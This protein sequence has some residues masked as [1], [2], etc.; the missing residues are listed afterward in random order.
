VAE[1]PWIKF[2]T[3]D[4]LTGVADLQ[5]EEIGIYTVLLALI[6]DKGGPIADDAAWLARRAGTST[7]KFN[8]VR[9]RLIELGKLEA[10]NGL[11]ANRRALDEVT[12]RDGKSA[13]ARNA[14]LTRWKVEGEP[15]LPLGQAAKPVGTKV[16]PRA[17]ARSADYLPKNGQING[18]NSEDKDVLISGNNQQEPQKSAIPGDADACFPSRAGAFQRSEVRITPQPNSSPDAARGGIGSLD[19]SAEHNHNSAHQNEAPPH[20]SE[21]GHASEEAGRADHPQ[22]PDAGAKKSRLD[23]TDLH[24]LFDA[25]CE[26]AAFRPVAPD[27]IN[28]AYATVEAWRG[29]RFNFEH[30]VV[31]V[32]RAAI[33][34]TEEP[35]RI[36][37][38]FTN[39]I[40]HAQARYDRGAGK[41]SPPPSRQWTEEQ[42]REYLARLKDQE[43]ARG[44]PHTSRRTN[45]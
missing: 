4:F 5:A 36:L 33:L 20:S 16:A 18:R 6:W 41:P 26:A 19:E 10:R 34:Q 31:P 27:A 42:Q 2:Y 7:R 23:D 28:R 44:G 38:R 3:S 24:A 9:I 29:E 35:T 30:V 21:G 15:E 14:A 17:R 45:P 8:Q 32:I 25:A 43:G 13:Q 12:K 40:R 39:A 22:G 11:L 1:S 37:N